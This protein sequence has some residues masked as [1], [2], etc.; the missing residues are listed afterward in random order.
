MIPLRPCSSQLIHHLLDRGRLVP[1]GE[2]RGMSY[3]LYVP[4]AEHYILGYSI[5]PSASSSDNEL[6]A[7][8][9]ED[10]SICLAIE[11]A[12]TGGWSNVT[13][14]SYKK[15]KSC[16]IIEKGIAILGSRLTIPSSLR[17]SLSTNYLYH[18]DI[19]DIVAAKK[20]VKSI[21]HLLLPNSRP[22]CLQTLGNAFILII[23]KPGN[24]TFSSL[25]IPAQNG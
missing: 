17:R 10:A 3:C 12:R 22:S 7:A 5:R 18:N 13:E 20:H 24:R 6:L 1:S 19:S 15:K 11:R 25:W 2:W 4:E 16:L 8:A 9:K 14:D 21:S 23:W